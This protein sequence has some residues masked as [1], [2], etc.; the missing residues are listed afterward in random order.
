M[1][2]SGRRHEATVRGHSP[3]WGG[4]QPRSFHRQAMY[5]TFGHRMLI[6]IST[7]DTLV[8][9]A[10][11]RHL[12][13]SSACRARATSAA[14]PASAPATRAACILVKTNGTRLNLKR[15]AVVLA[16]RLHVLVRREDKS[17]TAREPL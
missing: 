5:V 2:E 8:T 12:I 11:R 6:F 3:S 17:K 1:G 10:G 13:R 4:R 15:P 14:A 16:D 7:G 9:T